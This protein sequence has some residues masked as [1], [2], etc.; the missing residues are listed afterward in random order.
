M[1]TLAVGS[2]APDFS[3]PTSEGDKFQLAAC[4]GRWVVLYFYPKDMTPGCTTEACEFRDL[5]GELSQLGAVVVG[6]SGDSLQSHG[7][8]KEKHNLNFPLL[9]DSDLAVAK[10]YGAYGEKNFM[11]RKSMGILRTTYLIAPDG[12]VARVWEKVKAAGHAA[13]V[14]A[15]LREKQ[16]QGR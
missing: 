14:L 13:E 3:L 5:M 7:K 4:R 6:V 2:P 16:A 15:A 9:A 10:A 8:F 11:G 1:A 12:R